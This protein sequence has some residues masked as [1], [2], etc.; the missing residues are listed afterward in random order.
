M[1]HNIMQLVVMEMAITIILKFN[2]NHLSFKN[3]KHIFIL[4]NE[5]AQIV[6][7]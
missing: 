1:S 7:T 6:T 3:V 5:I 4:T 2:L